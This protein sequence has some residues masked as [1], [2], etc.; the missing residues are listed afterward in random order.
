MNLPKLRI[1]C[2]LL[3]L[4]L[5]GCGP[6]DSTVPASPLLLNNAEQAVTGVA[7]ISASHV[8]EA[9]N[10][11]CVVCHSEQLETAGLRLDSVDLTD[12][13]AQPELLEN[14]LLYTS[15]S[16]RDRG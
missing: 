16:P 3:V 13:S 9:I 12:V 10:Q 1:L 8:K 15:P 2:S 6:Q 7:E 11:Y 14:C 5:A 4:S